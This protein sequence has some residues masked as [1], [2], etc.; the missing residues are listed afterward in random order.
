MVLFR[1][2][3]NAPKIEEQI[4]LIIREVIYF[5]SQKFGGQRVNTYN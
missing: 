4:E 5:S 2:H 1:Y 3:M